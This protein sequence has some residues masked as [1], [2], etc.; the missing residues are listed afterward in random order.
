M[1]GRLVGGGVAGNAAGV[2]AINF[3]LRLS[4]QALLRR[5]R[6]RLS[7]RV[8]FEQ[9][10]SSDGCGGEHES[11]TGAPQPALPR[12]GAIRRAACKSR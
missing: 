6:R 10:R 12:T 11:S 3:G 9:Q 2:F 8:G 5:L 7:V 4:E 1:H